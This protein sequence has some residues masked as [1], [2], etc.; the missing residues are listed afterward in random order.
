MEPKILHFHRATEYSEP[1]EDLI[2]KV[3][4]EPPAPEEWKDNAPD[5]HAQGVRMANLLM[6]HAPGL[7]CRGLRD[8]LNEEL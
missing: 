4:L 3:I 2:I 5:Y 1:I 8:Q 7:T 6:E